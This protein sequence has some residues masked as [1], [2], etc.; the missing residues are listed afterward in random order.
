MSIEIITAVLAFLSAAFATWRASR[1]DE[2]TAKIEAQVEGVKVTAE[3]DIK[4][5]QMLTAGIE[6]HFDRLEAQLARAEEQ[7]DALT[8]R[9][10]QLWQER[11]RMMAWMAF[12]QLTWPP[13]PDSPI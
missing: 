5:E 1:K 2:S 13:P 12:N 7:I 4:R 6:A 11:E 10:D 8:E 9:V 3:L